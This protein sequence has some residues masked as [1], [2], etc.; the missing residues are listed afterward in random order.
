VK[1]E[2]NTGNALAVKKGMLAVYNTAVLFT[3]AGLCAKGDA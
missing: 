1:S 2:E 3:D